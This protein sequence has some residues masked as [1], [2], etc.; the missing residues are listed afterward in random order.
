MKEKSKYS[1][2]RVVFVDEDSTQTKPYIKEMGFRGIDV[3]CFT[4]PDSCLYEA[5]DMSEVDAF[6]LDVMLP[7][8]NHYSAEDTLEY[9]F[10]GV[11]LAR[12][13]R[14][15]HP[16]VPIILFSNHHQ[17]EEVKRIQ[18][19]LGTIGNCAFVRK[20]SVRSSVDF[21]DI[22]ERVLERGLG[23]LGTG[24]WGTIK[25]SIIIQPNIQGVGLDLKKLFNE[26]CQLRRYQ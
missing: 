24:L 15:W 7:S 11:F 26:I 1:K 14:G 13:L 25:D 9:R 12:D 6:V 10:T 23:S 17:D 22:I 8:I 18:K 16:R 21:G 20:Q 4:D 5:K 2:R 19:A 3:I